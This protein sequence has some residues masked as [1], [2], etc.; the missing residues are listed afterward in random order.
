VSLERILI[1]EDEPDI[2]MLAEMS[3]KDIGRLQVKL[4]NDGLE[5]LAML[6]SWWPDLILMDVMM[7]KLTGPET[8]AKLRVNPSTAS[9]P[10]VFMTAKSEHEELDAYRR[11]GAVAVIL[12]PFEPMTLA[13]QL[14]SIYAG[15]PR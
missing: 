4:A 2:Q 12:K 10:V 7:P 14:R 6:G 5:A 11:L 1:V 8:I 9:I 15:L 3:L 13:A